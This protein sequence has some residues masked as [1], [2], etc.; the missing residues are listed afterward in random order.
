MD[1]NNQFIKNFLDNLPCGAGIYELVNEEILLRYLN[2]V[3]YDLIKSTPEQVASSGFGTIIHPDDLKETLAKVKTAFPEHHDFLRE[4]RLR[5]GDGTYARFSVICHPVSTETGDIIFYCL[6]FSAENEQRE[7]NPLYRGLVE[8]VCEK[9]SL[10]KADEEKIDLSDQIEAIMGSLS[11]GVCAYEYSPSDHNSTILFANPGYY[12]LLG[13]TKEQ[14]NQEITNT[15]DIVYPEDMQALDE[16]IQAVSK[17]KDEHHLDYR[18]VKRD[19]AIVWFSLK[20]RRTNRIGTDHIVILCETVDITEQ[21]AMTIEKNAILDQITFLNRAASHLLSETD[22]DAAIHTVLEDVLDHFSGQRAYIFEFNNKKQTARN[23]YEVCA[24][25]VTTEKE[26]LQDV[27]FSL[28]SE[29]F[30]AFEEQGYIYIPN[31]SSLDDSLTDERELLQAQSIRCLLSV[32]IRIDSSLIGML[33]VDDPLRSA[34]KLDHLQA[35]G[36]YIAV[37]LS[38][39]KMTAELNDSNHRMEIM[40][41]DT[42]GGFVL[43]TIHPDLSITPYF[44]NDGFCQILGMTIEQVFAVYG[45]DAYGGVCPEDRARVANEIASIIPG[46]TTITTRFRFIHSS[47]NYVPVEVYY[48]V[49]EIPGEALYLNGYYRDISEKVALEENYQRNLTYREINDRNSLGSFHLNVTKNTIDDGISHEPKILAMNQDGMLSGFLEKAAAM[50]HNPESEKTFKTLF[51]QKALLESYA[52]GNNQIIFDHAFSLIPNRFLW[53]RS[54]VNLFKN[55][56]TGDIEGFIYTRDISDEYTLNLVMHA[57]VNNNFDFIVVINLQSKNYRS[58]LSNKRVVTEFQKRG[59]YN[60][61][62]VRGLQSI[63]HPEDR[64]AALRSMQLPFIIKELKKNGRLELRFRAI[65]NGEVCHKKYAYTF[66][67]ETHRD[68]IFSR[69]DETI[70]VV[71]MQH[72]LDAAKKAS[73]AKSDFLSRMSHDIRTPLNAVLGFTELAQKEPSVPEPVGDYLEKIYESGQYLLGLI[74]DVLDMSKIEEGKLVLH[75]EPYRFVD[76]EKTIRTILEPKAKKKGV[77]FEII[78]HKTIDCSVLFDKLHLQQIFLNLLGNAVKFTP[79]GGKVTFTLYAQKPT[80]DG[81]LPL[82]FIVQDTGIGMSEEFQ[83]KRMFSVFEQEHSDGQKKEDGT[84][85]GLSIAKQLI[86][87]MGG[88]IA[89]KSKLGEGTT[90]TVCLCPKIGPETILEETKVPA[91]L[92]VLSGK[93]ILICE[94]QPLNMQIAATLLKKQGMIVNIAENGKIGVDKFCESPT[95]FYDA[96]LMDIRMPVMDGLEAA[97]IIRK[98]DRPDAKKVV[99]IAMSANAFDE[100]VQ[101]SRAAGMNEHLPKP[102]NSQTLFNT[103]AE[104]IIRGMSK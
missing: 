2:R 36:D 34:D 49:W 68:I 1:E 20:A 88:T 94:D 45:N 10:T 60:D 59:N 99:I 100:D 14:F 12:K 55:P 23:T 95:G 38:R 47:G 44:V 72:A 67:D 103:L 50:Q 18:C 58:F 89:C 5:T 96:I 90:L 40:L 25:G 76:F 37:I 70:S 86:D 19:G 93:R 98:L 42:P 35:I 54:M 85:L 7:T 92:S 29:W 80:P 4:A 69:V 32:P 30:T 57:V 64:D 62:T 97:R 24:P 41:N 9:L 79:K 15:L 31:V 21:K 39:R 22:A 52:S 11:C 33:G 27:P 84:G 104:Q 71:Q 3:G 101:A 56:E 83:K 48:R 66:L 82:T 13:Y 65:I 75:P 16:L 78:N 8:N 51:S 28:F 26:N 74:N 91:L 73:A 17:D 53:I 87:Q 61:V 102:V 46:R 43:M 77:E 81:K 6:F 63:I